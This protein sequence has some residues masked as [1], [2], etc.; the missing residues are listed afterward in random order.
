V[1]GDSDRLTQ[2]SDRVSLVCR[3]LLEL[4]VVVETL[5]DMIAASNIAAARDL[6][7]P[8][9]MDDVGTQMRAHLIGVRDTLQ[10]VNRP[11]P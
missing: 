3:A 2:L 1:N 11:W 4:T 7:S 9:E 8:N 5:A 6:L 10:Q